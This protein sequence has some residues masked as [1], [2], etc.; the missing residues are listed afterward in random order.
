MHGCLGPFHRTAAR[1]RHGVFVSQRRRYFKLKAILRPLT[2][3]CMGRL[4]KGFKGDECKSILNAGNRLDL[5]GDEVADIF[6]VV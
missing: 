6:I 3:L 4:G 1:H 5:T 2:S